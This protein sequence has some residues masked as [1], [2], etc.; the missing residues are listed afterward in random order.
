MGL[1]FTIDSP[2]K[3]ARFGIASVISIVEDNLI[4]MMRRHYYPTINQPYFPIG[5]DVPDF[6][7]KRITDYLNLVNTIVHEQV[8]KIR[9]S[10]FEKG[11]EIVQYFE[12]LPIDS[13]VKRLYHQMMSTE[14]KPEKEK[15]ETYLRSSM[16]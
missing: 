15:L 5:T 9:K 11:A 3:V 4:E 2:I 13:K 7:A 16:V 14:N 8:E 12:M 1:A 10:A 6:R